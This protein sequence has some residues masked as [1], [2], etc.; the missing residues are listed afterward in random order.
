MIPEPN[1][2]KR[3]QHGQGG[4]NLQEVA[5]R[6]GKLLALVA[7]QD[8]HP[9]DG[10]SVLPLATA[11]ELPAGHEPAD[12]RHDAQGHTQP[13]H[14]HVP[15]REDVSRPIGPLMARRHVDF[16]R[17]L[18]ADLAHVVEPRIVETDIEES[19][20]LERVGLEYAEGDERDDAGQHKL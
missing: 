14:H 8:Q 1:E 3:R 10:Q 17:G 11:N 7:E 4:V 15:Q 5:H 20:P 12:P 18:R 6:L 13:P 2:E 16:A 9:G 19:G